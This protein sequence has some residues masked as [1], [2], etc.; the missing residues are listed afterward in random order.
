MS[1]NRTLHRLFVEV[2]REAKRNPGFADRLDAVLRTH[3]SV[4]VIDEASL[5][6]D[7]PEEEPAL[8]APVVPLPDINP[9][10]VYTRE[11]AD[12][13]KEALIVLPEAALTSLVGEH[14][15]D[16]A[17]QAAGLAKPALIDHIVAQAARRVERDRKL[18]DY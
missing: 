18:F 11:G 16:P 7:E 6:E 12:A 17:G 9:V 2:R 3:A 14:N 8:A 4:R 13:L 1:L 10:A 15:L 5:I